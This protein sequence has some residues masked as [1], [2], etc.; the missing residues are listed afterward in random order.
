MA[1]RALAQIL[2]LQILS[3]PLLTRS[4]TKNVY[5]DVLPLDVAGGHVRIS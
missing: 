2:S 3:D 4:T 5:C 1:S